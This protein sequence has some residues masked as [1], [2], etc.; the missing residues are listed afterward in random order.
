MDGKHRHEFTWRHSPGLQR[1]ERH[2]P[3]SV[4]K[5]VLHSPARRRS[6]GPDDPRRRIDHQRDRLA[7]RQ[8]GHRWG[9]Y[10]AIDIDPVDD[11][12]FWVI[13]EYVPTTSAIGGDCESARLTWPAAEARHQHQRP[14]RVQLLRRRQLLPL[15]AVNT[16]L[17]QARIRSFR[18][19]PT[20]VT[21]LMTAIPSS[22]CLSRS[23][24]MIRPITA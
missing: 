11:T 3:I 23:R 1:L 10:T 17:R 12:T 19:R 22:H 18:G 16:R 5:C 14:R 9:D 15:R 20:R 4:S 13:N 7:N 6:A 8:C 2:E 24:Y 21:I